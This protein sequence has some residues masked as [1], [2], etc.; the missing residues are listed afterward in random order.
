MG[1]TDNILNKTKA[2]VKNAINNANTYTGSI[3]NMVDYLQPRD[4]YNTDFT[5][6]EAYRSLQNSL[7]GYNAAAK[8]IDLSGIIADY[9][10]NNQA[11]INT[12]NK[13]LS[14]TINTLKTS[15]EQSRN[16]L[17]TSL[18]RF[19]ESNAENMR[20]Q[21]QDFNASRAS[22]EDES[23][24]NQRNSLANAA[25][26]GLGGSGLQQLAQLQNRL[27]AGKNIS[28]LAQKNQ[29]AQDALRRA[30]TQ[31]TEDTDTKVA[32]LETNLRNAIINAEHAK[33]KVII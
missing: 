10:R 2:T 26:R 12:L 19:Q 16:D 3:P 6:T 25:S 33:L 1:W 14:D 11:T 13:T 4:S 8:P 27:A 30:L 9:N 7:S 31:Q 32:N 23:F 21:Q 24:M 5:N 18:K 28:S 20:M 17:L 22:L 15:N 29:T